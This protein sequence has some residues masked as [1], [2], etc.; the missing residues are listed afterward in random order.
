MKDGKSF[1]RTS[2]VMSDV[3]GRRHHTG[4]EREISSSYWHVDRQRTTLSTTAFSAPVERRTRHKQ[5]YVYPRLSTAHDF[6]IIFH[7]LWPIMQGRRDWTNRQSLMGSLPFQASCHKTCAITST[8]LC[9]V[10]V[11]WRNKRS[12]KSAT[13]QRFSSAFLAYLT[14]SVFISRKT[15]VLVNN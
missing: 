14:S 10:L 11:L 2:L 12:L 3:T 9:V 4:A 5:V 7:D 6:L 8:A 13:S 1:S 15:C